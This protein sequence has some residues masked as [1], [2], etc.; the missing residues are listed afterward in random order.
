MNGRTL[1]ALN[2]RRLRLEREISQE[3]LAA[4]ATMDRAYVSEL[5]RRRGNAS[6]DL[7]DKLAKALKVEIA[8][9]FRTVEPGARKLKPLPVGR[10]RR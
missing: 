9:F 5:E 1:L 2:L 10:K 6:V 8:D 3:R 4:D 7:L